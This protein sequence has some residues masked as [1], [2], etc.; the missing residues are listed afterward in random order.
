MASTSDII[1]AQ[2]HYY[3]PVILKSKFLYYKCFWLYFALQ[4]GLSLTC[5]LLEILWYK[6]YYS[7][8]VVFTLLQVIVNEGRRLHAT[9]SKKS[10][11]QEKKGVRKLRAYLVE[12]L[13][14][15]ILCASIYTVF[16]SSNR[17]LM[18]LKAGQIGSMMLYQ[19]LFL[20]PCLAFFC[21]E[22]ELELELWSIKKIYTVHDSMSKAKLDTDPLIK[23][24]R[25]DP[26]RLEPPR[27]LERFY[28]TGRNIDAFYDI[29]TGMLLPEF[30]QSKKISTVVYLALTKVYHETG[31][32]MNGGVV[33]DTLKQNNMFQS[34][35]KF[36]IN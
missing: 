8:N 27:R 29:N 12:L 7:W 35:D 5:V 3:Y 32:I 28:C 23:Y 4:L 17:L 6:N 22:D 18:Y 25:V 21:V 20:R 19:W 13:V 24:Q 36:R 34:H 15:V 10:L 26:T 14:E 33:V 1:L 30:I 31:D 11:A 16:V 2:V 9:T